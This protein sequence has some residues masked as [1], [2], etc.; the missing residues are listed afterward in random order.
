MNDEINSKN[1]VFCFYIFFCFHADGKLSQ[2]IGA[3]V[4][5]IAAARAQTTQSKN[6]WSEGATRVVWASQDICKVPPPPPPPSPPANPPQVISQQFTSTIVTPPQHGTISTVKDVFTCSIPYPVLVP[7]T[8]YYYTPTAPGNDSITIT[9]TITTQYSDGANITSKTTTNTATYTL[10]QI[11]GKNLGECDKCRAARVASAE[12]NPIDAATGNKYEAET[13]FVGGPSTGVSLTRYYNGLDYVDGSVPPFGANWR[14]QWH[15]RTLEVATL[16]NGSTE[17]QTVRVRDSSGRV[18]VFAQAASGYSAAPDVTSRLRAVFNASNQQTG[19]QLVR[20]DD[21]VESY[22]IRGLLSSV[23]ARNGQ[24]TTLSYNTSNLLTS[25]TGPFNHALTFAY[26]SYGRVS[27][28]TVPGGQ[29]YK[30][31]YSA[32][33]APYG[34]LISVTYP[35]NS[36]RKYVY[37]NTQFPSALTGITDELNNSYATFSYDATGRAISSQHAGGA[38]LTK[39]AFD[40]DGSTT[41]TDARGNVHSYTLT[42]Q[43]SLKKATGLSGAPVQTS[44]GKAFAMTQTVS[45]RKPQTGTEMSLPE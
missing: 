35:D 15:A 11:P 34:N 12:A 42:S 41:V 6:V 1:D 45:S 3:D 23:T 9:W 7:T 24:V 2:G 36:V 31:A 20:D 29:V 26:D 8:F 28:V 37:G 27:Q 14:S 13:D 40:P 43:F 10:I 22:S 5:S 18:E 16:S 19:W 30:Y 25:V 38:E 32:T 44:G 39:L 17:T 4:F 33:P 21:T